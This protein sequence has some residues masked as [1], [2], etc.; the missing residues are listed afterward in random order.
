VDVLA[1]SVVVA[2]TTVEHVVAES[3]ACRGRARDVAVRIGANC[4]FPGDFI[5][6]SGHLGRVHLQV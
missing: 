3:I 5:E 1:H 6:S 4:H 2:T